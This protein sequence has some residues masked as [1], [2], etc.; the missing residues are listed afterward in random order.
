MSQP[1][2][3]PAFPE[4][5]ERPIEGLFM[6]TNLAPRLSIRRTVG[7]VLAALIGPLP[8][9]AAEPAVQVPAPTVD[10]AA[11]SASSETAVLAGGCFWGVQ[12]VFQH[13]AGVTRAESGYAGGS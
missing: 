12:G 2:K 1:T 7:A 4:S 9:F 5:R 13:V 11:G 6:P 8:A 10:V 3:T